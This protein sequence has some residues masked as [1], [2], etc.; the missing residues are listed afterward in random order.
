M[1]RP[2]SASKRLGS[3]IDESPLPIYLLDRDGKVVYANRACG[4]WV[5]VEVDRLEGQTCRYVAIFDASEDDEEAMAAQCLAAPPEVFAGQRRSLDITPRGQSESLEVTFFPIPGGV[6]VQALCIAS[7]SDAGNPR[8][9]RTVSES[10][11]EKLLGMHQA[12]RQPQ[13]ELLGDS[14]LARRAQGQFR[15]ACSQD[16]HTLIVGSTAAARQRIARAVHAHREGP[17]A[18]LVPVACDVLDAELLQT[19]IRTL[20][21]E[22]AD[23]LKPPTLL[24]LEVTELES[25]AAIELAGLLALPEFGLRVLATANR[26]RMMADSH[27][28]EDLLILLSQFVIDLPDLKDRP[29]DIPLIA[30]AIVEQWNGVHEGSLSGF[31]RSALEQ[32]CDHAWPGEVD[33]LRKVIQQAAQSATRLEIQASQLPLNVRLNQDNFAH[34]KR[35]PTSINLDDFLEQAEFQQ[36]EWAL[37]ADKGNKTRAAKRLGISRPRLIR[38]LQH[39][40]LAAPSPAEI[41]DFVEIEEVGAEAFEEIEPED[42]ELEGP[43]VQP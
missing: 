17:R 28:P 31:E 40:G 9:A 19:T 10:L 21:R 7:A 39:F 11:H 25:S 42:Q 22:E 34:P 12:A 2:K 37:Q 18:P 4:E 33:E 24:L 26:A 13:L 41:P 1:A 36:L 14:P 5:G 8:L 15:I 20:F 38:R 35:R 29:H 3:A 32:L 30:Q 27:L 23:G 16:E 6:G 43:D